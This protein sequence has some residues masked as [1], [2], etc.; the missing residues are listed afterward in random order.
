MQSF[1]VIFSCV[2]IIATI[3]PIIKTGIWWVRIFDYP[4]IQVAFFI[5]IAIVLS[6]VYYGWGNY[7]GLF[8]LSS[9][10]IA[11]IYQL[12]LI[13]KYTPLHPIQA[14][15]AL[16]RDAKNTI[17]ILES[18]I[19]MEN[20]EAE[21]LISL[22]KDY[23]PDVL[24]VNETDKWWAEQLIVLNS[25]FP[26]SIKKPLENT[27]GMLL[28]SR[29]PIKNVEINFLVEPDIPSFFATIILP[30]KAEVELHC[31]HPKPP[32]PGI[33]TYERDTEILLIG[34]RVRKSGKPAIVVGDLNDVAWSST[35]A[36][37]QRYSG[38]LDPRQGRGLYNTYNVFFPLFRYPL[39]H[40]FYSK[41]FGLVR[42]ERLTS[43]GSDHYPMFLELCYEK[44]REH[45]KNKPEADEEDKN[46]VEEKIEEGKAA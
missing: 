35:S 8:L 6:L 39:D 7:T 24:V 5:V 43:V 40:F 12:G 3:L 41:E 45:V 23:S 2:F 16:V 15:K 9:L 1:T 25:I 22:V 42:L 14:K 31:L 17:S 30:S 13:F 37:F 28:F 27:Y 34:K 46:E 36:L 26:Y 19:R 29:Y 10:A 18:N 44:N 4:R 21:K 38:L 32:M 33:P 11:L 20:R